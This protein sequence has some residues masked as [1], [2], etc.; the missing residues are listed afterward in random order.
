MQTKTYFASSVPAALDVARKE[1]GPE[2]MLLNS[3][4]AAAESRA[5]GRL[6]VTFAY[7]PRREEVQRP[8]GRFD[9]GPEPR[10][11]A[12]SDARSD[13]RSEFR[14]E[15]RPATPQNRP[16]DPFAVPAASRQ[17]RASR[18]DNDLE[19]LRRQVEALRAAVGG[20]SEYGQPAVVVPARVPFPGAW[21]RDNDNP[22]V[23]RMQR[24]GVSES[25]ARELVEAA[26]PRGGDTQGNLIDEIC[27]RIALSRFEELHAGETRMLA[28][29][30]P[31]GRGKTTSL[32]KVAVKFGIAHRVPVR[33]YQ[34]GSHGVG[35]QEQ[36]ARY[37]TILG[38]PFFASESLESLNLS[39]TG[40]GWKGL[41]LLD[42]PGIS[43]AATGDLQDL[44]RFFARRP[45][46]ERHLV[47]RADARSADIAYMVSRFSALGNLRLL[48]TGAE[49]TLTTG[50]MVETMIS[51]GL[52][53]TFSGT[54]QDIPDD[55]EELDIARLARS[56]C[57]ERAMA[58][59]AAG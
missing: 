23:M 10:P 30:G 47:L 52:G 26:A 12:R 58:V 1:L 44:G 14:P 22:M 38:V 9:L 36:L 55:L 13:A 56:V 18:S 24:N 33:I 48:F 11:E 2:A 59:P 16:A 54:G 49:E 19:E 8:G 17:P 43:P 15:T 41:V 42:T 32:V 4:P 51:T 50:A 39:L 6:E 57:T 25:L 3:K 34:V 46:I 20:G 29:V 37:A 28:F 21:G 40:D 53:S 31:A 7:E 27:R 35:C 5:F 45:E